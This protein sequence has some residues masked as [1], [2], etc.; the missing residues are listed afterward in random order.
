VSNVVHILPLGDL[1]QDGTVGFMDAL[2]FA[3]DYGAT[4]GSPR[5]DPYADINGNGV[6]DFLDA[7]VLAANFGVIT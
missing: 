6:I 5:Y 4:I 3:A 2:T 7:T 1:N